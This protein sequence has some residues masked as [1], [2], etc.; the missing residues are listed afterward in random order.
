MSIEA[1]CFDLD[2]TLYDYLRYAQ[3]GLD[4][5]GDYLEALTG[6]QYHAELFDIYFEEGITD[7]TF[8]VLAERHGLATELVDEMEEAYHGAIGPLKPYDDAEPVLAELAGTYRL[9]CITD[10]RGGHT[11]L[12]RLGIHE[13]FDEALVTGAIGH[14]K[15]DPEA[16]EYLLS[17]LSA[18]PQSA[19]YVGDDPRDFHAP[20][21]LGM[22]TVRLRRGRYADVEP[23]D[24]AAVPDNEIRRL[25]ELP[26]V[27][28]RID[29]VERLSKGK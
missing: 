26:N 2:D 15:Q 5:V 10:A 16:F 9:G 23:T 28:A 24:R 20:N 17:K 11:K 3:A 29:R 4:E 1:I 14:S 21:D 18:S 8:D 12:R 22:T 6:R 27:L 7:D 19:V 13:Y 25:D